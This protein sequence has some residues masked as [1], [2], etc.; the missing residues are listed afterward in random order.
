MR[1][2]CKGF[3]GGKFRMKKWGRLKI[4]RETGTPGLTENC[5]GRGMKEIDP[6]DYSNT[7]REVI[8]KKARQTTEG[9]LFKKTRQGCPL[10]PSAKA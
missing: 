8:K 7:L 5:I 2:F 3:A 1:T 10:C 4:Q 9:N 6:S